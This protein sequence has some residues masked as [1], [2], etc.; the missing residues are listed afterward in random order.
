MGMEFDHDQ[1]QPQPSRHEQ[2]HG[3]GH[4]HT[5]AMVDD[6]PKA[7]AAAT[8]DFAPIDSDPLATS[9]DAF[10]LAL[11]PGLDAM[12]A[13]PDL[14]T[15]ELD[16][17]ITHCATDFVN[18][19]LA[20]SQNDQHGQSSAPAPPAYLGQLVDRINIHFIASPD[21]LFIDSKLNGQPKQV[22]RSP[23]QLI[24]TLFFCSFSC[25][26]LPPLCSQTV[27]SSNPLV[28]CRFTS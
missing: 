6:D 28:L 11:L 12:S 1:P 26:S 27:P 2:D 10:L 16:A 3:Q 20:P 13:N 22:T 5:M 8:F 15:P 17:A 21:K 9:A 24:G 14:I 4:D 19:Y 18:L 25:V 23:L 7:D